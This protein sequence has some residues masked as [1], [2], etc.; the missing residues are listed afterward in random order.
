[1]QIKMLYSL[2]ELYKTGNI[3]KASDILFLTQQGLSRQIKALEEELGVTLFIR[4]KDGVSPTEICHQL[5]PHF[6][7]MCQ[8]YEDALN[9]INRDSRSGLRIGLSYGLSNCIDNHFLFSYIDAFPH[10]HIELQ[11]W[12]ADVCHEK[13]LSGKLDLALLIEPFDRTRL[14]YETLAR[15]SMYAAIHNSNP[16]AST[17]EP[18]PFCALENQKI[19]TGPADN[20]LCR[21]FDYCCK[22]SKIQPQRLMS[23]SYKEDFINSMSRNMGIAPLTSAMAFRITNPELRIRPL[24][25]PVKGKVCLCWERNSRNQ[26]T[27]RHFAAY[28]KEYFRQNPIKPYIL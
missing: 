21:F 16:L 22:I 7:S 9:I 1:M 13:L 28:C 19:I 14:E 3:S 27:V 23:S 26:K 2:L 17:D 18:L 8:S 12:T 11:E 10:I 15:D 24:I 20:A 5:I 4:K 6:Q 25:L